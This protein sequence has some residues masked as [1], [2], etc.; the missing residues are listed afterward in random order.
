MSAENDLLKEFPHDRQY[1]ICLLGEPMV[2]K[3]HLVSAIT[4][5]PFTHKPTA[6]ADISHRKLQVSEDREIV[7]IFW[8]LSGQPIFKNVRKIFYEGSHALI[9]AYDLTRSGTL[10]ALPNWIKEIK[11]NIGECP[12]IL[13]GN[14]IDLK[15]D[16]KIEKELGQK[17][18]D[19]MKAK[20]F[21]E[22]SAVTK[23]HLGDVFKAAI[24]EAIRFRGHLS[25]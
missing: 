3:T 7:A 15:N 10:A 4:G 9:Y 25:D 8:D 6:G 24:R 14:K 13:V 23:A 20:A 11:T 1:K 18:A 17:F 19:K 12:A 22:T 5:R 16:R 21:F 2:G